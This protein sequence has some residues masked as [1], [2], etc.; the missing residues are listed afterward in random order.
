[1]FLF[2]GSNA[3]GN[4][5]S[6]GHARLMAAAPDLLVALRELH[7]VCQGMDHPDQMQRPEEDEYLAA[8]SDAAVALQLVDGQ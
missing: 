1:M 8:M 4:G 7:R 2:S 5:T 3:I 6:E